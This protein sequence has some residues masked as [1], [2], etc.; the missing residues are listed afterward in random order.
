MAQA[1]DTVRAT[2]AANDY[3][4]YVYGQVLQPGVVSVPNAYYFNNRKIKN[5]RMDKA[6]TGGLNAFWNIE[7]Q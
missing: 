5:Y 6:A 7:L 1:S 2:A 3:L 4:A